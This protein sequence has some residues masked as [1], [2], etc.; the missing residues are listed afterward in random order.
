MTTNKLLFIDI[1]TEGLKPKEHRIL[2]FAAIVVD[3]D[4][5]ELATI[6]RAFAY[7]DF[8]AA[9]LDSYVRSMHEK[10]GLLGALEEAHTSGRG[11]TLHGFDL[12]L[13]NWL[14]EQGCKAG[15]V[16]LAGSSVH[17]DS[18]FIEEQM[19]MLSWVKHYRR[20]DT[21]N[22]EIFLKDCGIELFPGERSP[23]AHRALDDARY[24]LRV[25]RVGRQIVRGLQG[26]AK[27]LAALREASA[28]AHTKQVEALEKLVGAA[29]PAPSTLAEALLEHPAPALAPKLPT[30]K[31]GFIA[32]GETRSYQDFMS[33]AVDS[34]MSTSDARFSAAWTH[35]RKGWGD[36][37]ARPAGYYGLT[38]A[39]QDLWW[40]GQKSIADIVDN[41]RDALRGEPTA[42]S[43][44]P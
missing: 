24:A 23:V 15:E 27:A 42:L 18:G 11:R 31:P 14:R 25:A 36:G 39:E 7:D 19:P 32:P 2:E 30:G 41:R 1:E 4:L 38:D 16:I 33:W 17:F 5:N 43:F 12:E 8:D 13:P 28:V 9:K 10:S 22:I 29:L 3:E 44:V 21:R 34:E 35:A 20:Y 37:P 40:T 26:D 6:T